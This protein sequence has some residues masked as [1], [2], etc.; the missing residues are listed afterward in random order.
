[1][2]NIKKHGMKRKR[3][4]EKRRNEIERFHHASVLDV[5]SVKMLGILHEGERR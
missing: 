4:K 1:M 3:K 2:S 5:K